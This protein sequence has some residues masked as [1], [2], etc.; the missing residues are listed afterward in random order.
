MQ[1]DQVLAPG[2]L[3]VLPDP[4]I[5]LSRTRPVELQ[6]QQPPKFKPLAGALVPPDGE[7]VVDD[8]S[9]G[10]EELVVNVGNV[11]DHPSGRLAGQECFGQSVLLIRRP[12]KE[13]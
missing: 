4:G 12:S 10:L 6:V 13:L 11:R 3:A 8:E 9:N 1:L 5:N 2:R 7:V